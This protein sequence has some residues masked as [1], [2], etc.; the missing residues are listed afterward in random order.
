MAP[1]AIAAGAAVPVAVAP[2]V[3]VAA[4][5]AGTNSSTHQRIVKTFGLAP[6]MPSLFYEKLTSKNCP[7]FRA[8]FVEF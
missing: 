4:A 2:A 1:V 5:A 6:H 8:V 7:T 3:E